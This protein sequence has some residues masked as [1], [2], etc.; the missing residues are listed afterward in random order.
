MWNFFLTVKEFYNRNISFEKK[1]NLS[2]NAA[3]NSFTI[4][5]FS[6]RTFINFVYEKMVVSYV[7]K[8]LKNGVS[9]RLKKTWDFLKIYAVYIFKNLFVNFFFRQRRKKN[10]VNIR[11]I[12][13]FSCQRPRVGRICLFC[14]WSSWLGMLKK[15]RGA[16]INVVH[17][18]VPGP[19]IYWTNKK[20]FWPESPHGLKKDIFYYR[21]FEKQRNIQYF[22]QKFYLVVFFRL[23]KNEKLHR[24]F[25]GH[26]II[27]RWNQQI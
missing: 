16:C 19:K 14:L 17:W 27:S 4:L 7:F 10:H 24:K 6:S 15:W 5:I 3:W 20:G 23:A 13:C 12:K 18:N 8:K 9:C 11:K 25:A 26:C 21:I 2:S 1:R 22:V